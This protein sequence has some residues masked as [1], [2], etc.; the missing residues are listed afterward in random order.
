MYD[1]MRDKAIDKCHVSAVSR[2]QAERAS[3]TQKPRKDGACPREVARARKV[4]ALQKGCK[5]VR[6]KDL[7]G[8]GGRESKNCWEMKLIITAS[9]MIDQNL[10]GLRATRGVLRVASMSG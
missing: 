9:Q 10:R 5:K 4:P 2:Q 1:K 8:L 3:S 7:G 6:Q